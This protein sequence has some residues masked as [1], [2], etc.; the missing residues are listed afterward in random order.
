MPPARGDRPRGGL[1][2]GSGGGGADGAGFGVLTWPL[3]LVAL[4]LTLD[5]VAQSLL[6]RSGTGW[7]RG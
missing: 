6:T 7:R 2:R 1:A 3:A 5:Q 4:L